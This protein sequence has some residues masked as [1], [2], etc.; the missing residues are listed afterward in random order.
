MVDNNTGSNSQT[1]SNPGAEGPTYQ[2]WREQRWKDR[3]EWRKKR[4][5]AR[6]KNP[7]RGVFPGLALIL[8]GGLFLAN[9]MSWISGDTWWKWL[10]VGLGA[11]MMISW[12]VQY[13]LVPEYRG[14]G[15]GRFIWGLAL[16][17][18]GILFLLGVSQWWP[19]ILIGAGLAC[20]FRFCW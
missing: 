9:Q 15:R 12:L 4:W 1:G 5:E 16:A 6:E 17:V 20:L 3:M 19:I 10:L 14:W 8:A 7:F 2:D 13:R 18:L 11:I